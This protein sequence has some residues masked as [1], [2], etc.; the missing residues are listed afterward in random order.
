[1]DEIIGADPALDAPGTA[2]D[3][4]RAGVLPSRQIQ[5][6]CGAKKL[7]EFR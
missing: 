5:C 6:V 3:L 1:M 7:R 4:A 2:A